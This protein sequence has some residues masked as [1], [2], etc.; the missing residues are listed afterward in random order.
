MTQSQEKSYLNSAHANRFIL[1]RI[2]RGSKA[3]TLLGAMFLQIILQPLDHGFPLLSLILQLSLI[4]AIIFMVADSR[5]HLMT[6]LILGIP[7]SLLLIFSE[8]N[9]YTTITWIAYSLILFLY[10]H[11]L[12]LMMMQIFQTKKI[13]LETIALAMC[14]YVLLGNLWT[15]LYIPV[16]AFSPGAFVLNTAAGAAP[17]FDQLSY[18]SFVTLTTLG[19]GDVLP[20]APLARSLAVLEALTGTLFLAVL[21]SRLVGSYSSERRDN[22]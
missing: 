15:I 22:S 7:A 12:R 17:I 16:A 8:R 10:L 18:F 14:T 1:F 5:L 21:I 3:F 4:F 2:A 11:V 19:Y 13:T 20:V 9:G 6:G